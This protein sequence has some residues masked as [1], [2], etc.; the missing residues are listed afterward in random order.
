MDKKNIA[1]IAGIIFVLALL[2]VGLIALG[3]KFRSEILDALEPV[4]KW[5]SNHPYWTLVIVT[6]VIIGML[7][8]VMAYILYKS[9]KRRKYRRM[10]ATIAPLVSSNP[11]SR[12]I[13]NDTRLY[14]PRVKTD[15]ERKKIVEQIKA[16]HPEW[17]RRY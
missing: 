12:P 16:R 17:Y 13:L 9:M 2:I 4:K 10:T 8:L 3:V 1:I 5:I 6:V 11:N 15:E 7:V 14:L